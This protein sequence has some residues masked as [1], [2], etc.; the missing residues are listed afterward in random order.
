MRIGLTFDLRD[1][2]LA[3][4]YGE[5]ETAEFDRLETIDELEA[6]LR[7]CGHDVDRIGN[8]RALVKRLA[9]GASW[10]L[11][12]NIAE[13]LRGF[14]REA[15]I[16]A[17]LEAYEIPYTFSDTL[18]SSVTL[19]KGYTKRILR[20]YGL[21]TSDFREVGSLDELSDI[22]LPFPL[23][24]K[25]IAEGT[26]KGI[27]SGSMVTTQSELQDA[28]ERVLS[29]FRQPALIEPYLPGR[30][31]TVGILGTGDQAAAIGTL[32]VELSADAEPHSYTYANKER[33]ESLCRFPPAPTAWRERV[34]PI[35]LA[36]WR[37]LGCRDAGRVDL[38]AD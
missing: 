29:E 38:R 18:T 10:E 30:E 21:P 5:E 20:D 17:L 36:A 15:Q 8:V 1:D 14:G 9:A 32:E 24:A 27:H 28:V 16:P 19:H 26:A 3:A 6:A 12:F 22:D 35:A 11:V 7:Q 37:A 25:P 4:G 13:G 2:Y 34:E 23:F 33:C 31:F